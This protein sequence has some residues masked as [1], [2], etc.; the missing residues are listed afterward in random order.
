[1]KKKLIYQHHDLN[2]STKIENSKDKL[3]LMVRFKNNI[4]SEIFYMLMFSVICLVLVLI[5]ANDN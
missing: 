3:T 4:K 1:M 2:I 5:S